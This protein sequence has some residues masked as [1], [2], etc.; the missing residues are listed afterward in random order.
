MDIIL[1]AGGLSKRFLDSYNNAN[2]IENKLLFK[3]ND[4]LIIEY[5]LQTFILNK[6]ISRIIV[7]CGKEIKQCLLQKKYNIIFANRGKTRYESFVNGLIHVRSE[8]FLIHDGAR[9]LVS[10]HIINELVKMKDKYNCII[11]VLKLRDTI[12]EIK[13]NFIV[14]TLDR[15]KL[16]QIQ[17][18]QLMDLKLIKMII[19]NNDLLNHKFYDDSEIIEKFLKNEKIYYIDGDES[20]IKITTY[21][22]YL[23]ICFLISKYSSISFFNSGITS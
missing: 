12:K 8:K 6:N 13:N 10:N 4:K 15:N 20:N 17:T 22:D 1:L 21:I 5:S 11:P 14:K 18:P 3:I 7:V 2:K 23:F 19:D 9:P 16:V